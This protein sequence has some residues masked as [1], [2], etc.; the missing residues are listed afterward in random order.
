MLNPKEE[1]WLVNTISRLRTQ[2]DSDDLSISQLV[3]R[4]KGLIIPSSG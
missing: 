2:K 4:I 3:L 1:F